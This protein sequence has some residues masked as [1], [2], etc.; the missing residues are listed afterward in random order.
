M[1]I[2]EEAKIL[3]RSPPVIGMHRWCRIIYEYPSPH[4]GRDDIPALNMEAA[5]SREGLYFWKHASHSL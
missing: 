3:S 1:P 5:P 4:E 2:S